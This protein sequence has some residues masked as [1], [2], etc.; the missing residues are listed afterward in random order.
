VLKRRDIPE[1]VADGQSFGNVGLDF[2]FDERGKDGGLVWIAR[3][4]CGPERYVCRN[5]C[6]RRRS[7][8]V[9]SLS[10]CS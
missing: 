3:V 10:G 6:S 9:F 5:R 2:G 7:V 1:I 4:Q 8:R